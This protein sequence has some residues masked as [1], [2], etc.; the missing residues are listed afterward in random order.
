MRWVKRGLFA[1]L[2]LVF[3]LVLLVAGVLV[4][5]NTTAGQE[6]AVREVNKLGKDYVHLSGLTGQFPSSFS[7]ASL[8]LKDP[9]GDWLNA[10]NIALR[11]SPLAML[12]EHVKI[13][14]FTVERLDVIRSPAYPAT[15]KSKK[16]K[17]S[18][19]PV[20]SITINQFMVNQLTL[21]PAIAG[22]EIVL[23]ASGH[24]KLQDFNHATLT[25]DMASLNSP[26]FYRINGTLDPQTVDLNLAVHEPQDGL[27][28]HLSGLKTAPPVNVTLTLA[29]PRQDAALQGLVALGEAKLTLA[30]KLNLDPQALASDITLNIPDLAP[31]GALTNMK[32]AGTLGAHLVASLHGSDVTLTHLAVTGPDFNVMANGRVSNQALDL[33]STATLNHVATLMPGLQGALRLDSQITGP[34]QDFNATAT[35]SGQITTASVPSGPFSLQLKAQNL[36]RA[37]HG[38]LVGNGEL[39]GSALV[40]NAAFSHA[41]TG[42]ST[43]DIDTATWK[44]LRAQAQLSLAPQAKLPTGKALLKVGNLADLDSFGSFGLRGQL[45]ADFAYQTDQRLIVS[46]TTQKLGVGSILSGLNSNLTLNGPLE[47]LAV[48]LKATIAK[49]QNNP[50]QLEAAGT[51]NEPAMSFTLAS[52]TSSWHG[53]NAKLLGPTSITTKPNVTVDHLDLAVNR[54]T[55]ALNGL[56]YPT[57]NA[58]AAVKNLD[59]SIIRLFAPTV[60]AAGIISANATL[61]GPLKAPNGTIAITG[62]GLRYLDGLPAATLNAKAKLTGQKADV[63]ITL[64]AGPQARLSLRGSA[65]LA[66]TAPMNL[67]LTSNIALPVLNPLLGASKLQLSGTLAANAHITGTPQAPAGRVS[68]NGSNL[69]DSVGPAAALAPANLTATADIKNMLARVNMNVLAGQDIH[70][71]LQG[72]APLT[73]RKPMDLTLAGRVDLKALDPILAANGSLVRGI[74][75]TNLRVRGTMAAPRG[76]GM[77]TLADGSLLN[78]SSGLN[79]TK[80]NARVVATDQLVTLQSLTAMAGKGSLNGSGTIGLAGDM[81]VNLALNAD[82]A[83]PIISDLLSETLNGGLTL[84]GALKTG[85]T[86]AGTIDI[87]KANI[88]IPRSLPAS[89]ANLPIHYEGEAPLAEK[90]SAPP[91]PVRLD[92]TVKAEN[93]IF[94]R[95]EGLFAELGGRLHLGGTLANLEPTGGFT[96]VRGNFSLAGKTLQFNSGK[97]E[98]NGDGFIPMLDLEATTATSNDG[99]A[100][101]IISG[102]ATKPQINL[103]SS[104]PLPSDEI[105]AQLLFAQSSASLS[106]FQAASLAAALAQIAG[107]GG[108]F[109]P[110]DSARHALGLDQLSLD[111]TGKGGPSV[112]AGRYVAPGV[113]VGASQSTTGE[114]TKATVE[115]NLYKGL[116]LQS[117]TG[118]DSTGQS[119]SSVG[120]SYQFNY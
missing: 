79:L 1:L 17:S 67:T 63:N 30:G 69:H 46:L 59:L 102:A 5:L 26:A 49:L 2:T 60:H 103:T 36:P 66:M 11:W 54:A 70:F 108:G 23:Q 94:I 81:P 8:S 120:L 3:V 25:L 86:L 47:A 100:S 71:T 9:R 27:L 29:G 90:Q 88:N 22:Q 21:G 83:S 39:A 75:N 55:L 65:P 82:H 74:V 53:L 41:Q 116:K 16:S 57:L 13:E 45:N 109:S 107:V 89:V 52:L 18:G 32:L 73:K 87:L 78:I 43:V 44:S 93:Q 38:T 15:P 24:A 48:T 96:L 101:L 95:G 51:L 117:S 14:S 64:D 115:I 34:V 56:L 31:F 42:A 37:P 58:S 80:I 35:L 19:L 33:T 10:Q 28:S 98:F 72:S 50:A 104:P 97:I 99:T 6:F 111:S 92:L 113:Y 76:D 62:T 114:G 7:I 105:L 61:I 40:L 112:N 68:L 77:L 85:T 110:L 4:A 12:G 106:P 91:P 119:S 84:Q 20:R 118:T